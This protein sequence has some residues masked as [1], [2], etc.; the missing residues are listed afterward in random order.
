METIFRACLSVFKHFYILH[1]SN[2]NAISDHQVVQLTRWA[3]IHRDK[4]AE[5]IICTLVLTFCKLTD[6]QLV[7]YVQCV[8]IRHSNS[9]CDYYPWS[10]ANM[11]IATE[12]TVYQNIPGLLGNQKIQKTQVILHL[13]IDIIITITKFSHLIGYHQL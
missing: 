10:L 2:T 13:I 4:V 9:K 11:L 8:I 1:Y 3:S 7:S 5:F 12:A 6:N